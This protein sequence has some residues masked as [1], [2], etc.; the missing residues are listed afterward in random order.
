M[1]SV[2]CDACQVENGNKNV[3]LDTFWI[4]PRTQRG[5]KGPAVRDAANHDGDKGLKGT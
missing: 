2:T 5:S 4:S 1:D 3:L